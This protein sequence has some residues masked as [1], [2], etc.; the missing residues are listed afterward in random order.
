MASL[1]YIRLGYYIEYTCVQLRGR[2]FFCWPMD[3]PL[4]AQPSEM[5]TL[6]E[7]TKGSVPEEARTES[8]CCPWLECPALCRCLGAIRDALICLEE[9]VPVLT[10]IV[11]LCSCAG[12]I[13]IT[14]GLDGI[15][16]NLAFALD[17]KSTIELYA[18]LFTAGEIFLYL[19][20]L[21]F[22]FPCTKVGLAE[23]AS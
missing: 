20:V 16:D 1:N 21:L 15:L 12:V 10:I 17:F 2:I 3:E 8:S 7:D 14:Y 6:V 11:V 23:Y 19:I 5:T 22:A 4:L 18:G 9:R 13:L